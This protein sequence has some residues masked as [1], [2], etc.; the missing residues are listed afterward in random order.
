MVTMT[1]TGHVTATFTLNQYSIGVSA[2]PAAGGNVSGG[3]NYAHGATVSVTAT[4][5]A[6]YTFTKPV[7]VTVA[8]N[9]ALLYWNGTTWASDGV[10]F[11]TRDLDA[12]TLTVT[13]AHLS[14]FALFAAPSTPTNLEPELEPTLTSALYLPAVMSDASPVRVEAPDAS[15][16]ESPDTAPVAPGEEMGEDREKVYLPVVNIEL[17]YT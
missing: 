6:G 15:V 12:H 11:V 4:A 1:E 5:N 10:T 3:G 17:W 9:P 13:L 7:T 14:E 16:A 8:Y 2:D